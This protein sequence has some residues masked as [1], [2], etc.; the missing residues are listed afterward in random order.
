MS[1]PRQRIT[2]EEFEA[3]RARAA[4]KLPVPPMGQPMRAIA[5]AGRPWQARHKYNA[6]RVTL[7]GRKFAS[8]A[9]AQY[10][11]FLTLKQ[12]AGDLSWFIWQVPFFTPGE[13]MAIKYV[14]DFMEFWSNG[15][16]KFRDVKGFMTPEFKLKRRAVQAWYPI[17]IETVRMLKSGP[18]YEKEDLL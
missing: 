17:Q 16:I 14:L 3:I 5:S 13:P 15:D 1:M 10:H 4:S 2:V 8:K 7:D 6:H 11:A 18:R 12:Q 9:E